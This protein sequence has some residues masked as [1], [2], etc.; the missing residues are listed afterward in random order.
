MKAWWLVDSLR[1]AQERKAIEGLVNDGW[2]ELER[3]YIH[4][5]NLTVS[6][7]IRIHDHCYP[8]NLVYPD[9]FPEVPA[10]VV[11][12]D[13]IRWSNHQYGT[14]GILC[15]ELRPDNWIPTATGANV[16]RSAFNLLSIEDPLGEGSERIQAPSE[17][18]IGEIQ[19]YDWLYNPVLIGAGCW[20]RQQNEQSETLKA[21]QWFSKD[22]I[23]PILVHDAHD[24]LSP[25]HPPGTDL[26]TGVYEI[27][28]F[29]CTD[30]ISAEVPKSRSDLINFAGLLSDMVEFEAKGSALI[31]FAGDAVPLAYFLPYEGEPQL[32]KVFVLP[33]Q[34]DLRSGRAPEAH[35]KKVSI[36]GLGSVGSKIA[37]SIVR[38][39]ICRLILVDGDVMLPSNLER[40][41][42]DWREVGFRKTQG[43]RRR[44]LNIT[45][46]ADIQ[47]ISN[48][49]AWQ[50]SATAH[51]QQIAD[52]A[53]CDLIIDATG[54]PATS[55]FLGAIAAVNKRP[56]VSVEVYAGGIGALIASCL[57]ERDPPF[58]TARAAFLA[59]CEAE[60]VAPPE[61]GPHDYQALADDSTPL[62]ADD[63]AVTIAAGHAS[64]VILDILDGQPAGNESAWLLIGLRKAWVFQGH[65]H[66]IHL[67][68]GQ[69]I[70]HESPTHDEEAHQFALQLAKEYLDATHAADRTSPEA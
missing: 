19:A 50:R 40:H 14:G 57:P 62:V 64:R 48:N 31:L 15:L 68:V 51:A 13:N 29:V 47:V 24:R 33:D 27:P 53:H 52:I 35:P 37:D 32:R 44:L 59:W 58:A 2:F 54:D 45:P 70:E 17:H 8:V 16:L 21:L 56:F 20:S 46:G 6:G 10:W 38:S 5:C 23:S 41:A 28:I 11:P 30:S 9:Q 1:L 67:S 61:S 43:L 65:G 49:L 26:F 39:G 7:N 34:N 18:L 36:I 22:D 3:W 69:P 4:E 55:L 25:R 66:T 42:L 12:Q 63:A 60:G